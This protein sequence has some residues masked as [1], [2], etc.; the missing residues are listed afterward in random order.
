M[1]STQLNHLAQCHK[2]RLAEIE[3]NSDLSES[4]KAKKRAEESAYL[5]QRLAVL[6]LSPSAYQAVTAGRFTAFW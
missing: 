6:K 3:A 4:G 5:R 1:N 2:N